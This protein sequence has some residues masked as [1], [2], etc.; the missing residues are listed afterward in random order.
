MSTHLVP[1]STLVSDEG[2]L[3]QMSTSWDNWSSFQPSVSPLPF[4]FFCSRTDC[5]ACALLFFL[6][7]FCSLFSELIPP[8]SVFCYFEFLS[9]VL[10]HNLLSFL[11]CNCNSSSLSLPF[12]LPSERLSYCPRDTILKSHPKASSSTFS[13]N[14]NNTSCQTHGSF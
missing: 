8:T 9:I 5:G 10:L 13:W 2:D 4:G 7:P 6:S 11:N 3:S 12:C 1:F 14:C